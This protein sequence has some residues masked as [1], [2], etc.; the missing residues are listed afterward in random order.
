MRKSA[1]VSRKTLLLCPLFTV[2]IPTPTLDPPA[3]RT[4]SASDIFQLLALVQQVI[5]SNSSSP[6]ASPTVKLGGGLKIDPSLVGGIV[7]GLLAVSVIVY[8]ANAR[9]NPSEETLQE[10]EVERLAREMRSKPPA[11]NHEPNVY[12]PERKQNETAE[13]VYTVERQVLDGSA[14]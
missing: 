7:G 13:I 14:E 3:P 10:R 8:C 6:S 2:E 9:L 11:H 4:G 5:S 12:R 1:L